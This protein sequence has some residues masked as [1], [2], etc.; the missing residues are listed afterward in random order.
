MQFGLVTDIHFGR[1]T[2][3]RG[4]LRKLG[5]LA[6]PLLGAFV[7]RMNALEDLDFVVNLGDVIEDEGP[8]ED[9]ALYSKFLDVL[10]PVACPVKHVA[11]NH[12]LVNLAPA[13]LANLWG[14]PGELHYSERC[15]SLRLV[16]L[17]SRHAPRPMLPGDQLDWLSVELAKSSEPVLVFVHHPLAEMVLTG[18]PW[19]EGRTEICLVENRERVRSV[20]AAS[21]KVLGV[22]NGHVHWNHV[23]VEAGIPYVSLQS[24]TENVGSS[25]EPRPAAAHA[26]VDV[27]ESG[28]ALFID[29]AE[30]LRMQFATRRQ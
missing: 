26:I 10:K 2:K 15:G 17:S 25:A 29:G 27:D 1:Q 30:R 19:F 24:L 9:L 11:G 6:E 22:F 5:H 12:D 23:Y 3:H 18:N 7:E 8:S 14:R 28:L 13:Q 20:L 21:G 4:E 16:V